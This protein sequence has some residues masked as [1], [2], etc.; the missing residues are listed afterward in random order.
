MLSLM[1]HSLG[2]YFCRLED[3]IL[4]ENGEIW[5]GNKKFDKIVLTPLMMDFGK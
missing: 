3:D 1:E 2:D 4:D 5:I